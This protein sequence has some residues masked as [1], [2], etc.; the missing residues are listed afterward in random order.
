MSE[1]IGTCAN[2]NLRRASRLVGQ[3]Y[4][5]HLQPSGLRATQFTLLVAIGRMGPISISAL[6]NSMGLERTTLTRNLR[7][8]ERDQL[9]TIQGG[10]DARVRLLNLTD[11]ASAL[12]TKTLPYWETAQTDLLNRFGKQRWE[13]LLTELNALSASISAK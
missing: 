8:L 9:I 5:Q 6:A 10:T 4:D 11:K 3:F 12:I 1:D 13:K 2:M 7:R